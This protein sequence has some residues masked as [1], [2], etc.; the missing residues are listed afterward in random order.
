[1]N[2]AWW[3]Y[4][5]G[6]PE[7]EAAIQRGIAMDPDTYDLS[8]PDIVLKP[9]RRWRTDLPGCEVEENG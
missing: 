8:D 4:E 5:P 6:S 7:E 9:F 1:M 3:N 2:E